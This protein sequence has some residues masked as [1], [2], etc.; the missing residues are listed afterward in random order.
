MQSVKTNKIKALYFTEYLKTKII[1]L[2][3]LEYFK[4]IRV[5][6]KRHIH[7]RRIDKKWQKIC[8]KKVVNLY[9]NS[10]K[11]RFLLGLLTFSST[12]SIS[13]LADAGCQITRNRGSVA[14]LTYNGTSWT[15]SD[16]LIKNPWVKCDGVTNYCY[17]TPTPWYFE[18]RLDFLGGLFKRSKN[19]WKLNT[20]FFSL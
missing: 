9:Y 19:K 7:R 12:I 4:K 18:N 15:G 1:P 8:Q 17:S 5:V 11:K 3:G 13:F 6:S 10:M 16:P 14:T 20:L 2:K